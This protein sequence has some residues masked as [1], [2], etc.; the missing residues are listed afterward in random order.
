MEELG[1]ETPLLNLLSFLALSVRFFSSMPRSSLRNAIC[2]LS[3]GLFLN[4]AHAQSVTPT[5]TTATELTATIA[6]SVVT[7]SPKF[8]IPAAAD[9]GADLLPNIYDS[10]AVDAQSVC[11]GYTASNYVRNAYGFSASLSL[12][13]EACNIYGTVRADWVDPNSCFLTLI[14]MLTI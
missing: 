3:T 14:R 8:T 6:G 10:Q 1:V 12:A 5:P 13:G 7:Y 9:I 4:I 2:V 11:P